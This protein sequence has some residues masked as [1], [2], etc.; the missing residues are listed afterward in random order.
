MKQIEVGDIVKCTTYGGAT[1]LVKVTGLEKAGK[2][3]KDVFD[4]ILIKKGGDYPDASPIGQSVWGYISQITQVMKGTGKNI[5]NFKG[6]AEKARQT[7]VEAFSRKYKVGDI[8]FSPIYRE[9]KIVKMNDKTV[10]VLQV[11]EHGHPLTN[12]GYIKAKQKPMV[13]QKYLFTV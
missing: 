1:R 5:G 7:K 9:C 13:V 10:L 3:G 4:G 8:V 2:N 12:V 6:D 11:D